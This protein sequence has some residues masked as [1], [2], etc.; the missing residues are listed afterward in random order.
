[1]P[2]EKVTALVIRSVDFSETSQV[3]TVFSRELGKL[4]GL[5]KGARR[6]KGPFTGA[7]DLLSVCRIVL[8]RKHSE[9]LDLLTDAEL[10]KAFAR[11]RN[12]LPILYA[13]FYIAELLGELSDEYD[14]H[15]ALFD[16]AV[17]A[18]LQLESAVPVGLVLRR[19]ELRLL[20]EIGHAPELAI[21]VACGR[22]VA[23]GDRVRFSVRAGGV[24]CAA[25]QAGQ[26]GGLPLRVGSLRAAA[27]LASPGGE[28]WRRLDVPDGTLRE[29]RAVTRA[30]IEQLVSRK[31]RTARFL[32][33]T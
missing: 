15:P 23:P 24:L 8:L 26:P 7:L 14:P 3:V 2:F 1:V 5:A 31:L 20:H 10:V 13:G 28:Q 30:A 27:T 29:I 16:A 33:E 4:T 32:G 9:S 21:C 17:D 18:L 12:S 11:Q 25:C 22:A 6:L 19:F